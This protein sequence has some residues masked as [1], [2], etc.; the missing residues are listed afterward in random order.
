MRFLLIRAKLCQSSF[1]CTSESENMS[2]V[3]GPC[4]PG[5]AVPAGADTLHDSTF[6]AVKALQDMQA[7]MHAPDEDEK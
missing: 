6:Q 5:P 3:Q 1:V 7:I 4:H 2:L